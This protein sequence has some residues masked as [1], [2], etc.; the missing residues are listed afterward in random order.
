MRHGEAVEWAYSRGITDAEIDRLR[1]GDPGS[2]AEGCRSMLVWSRR[3]FISYRRA[4]AADLVGRLHDWLVD[5]GR[6]RVFL[7]SDSIVPSYDYPDVIAAELRRCEVLLAIIGPA[8]STRETRRAAAV[9]T[10][11]RTSCAWRSRPR[12]N[13]RCGSFRC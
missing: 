12:Y 2:R 6:H 11:P 1:E 8:G 5:R 10:I 3:I 7:D 9:W 13:A 4:E